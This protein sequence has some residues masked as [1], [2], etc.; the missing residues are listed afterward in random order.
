MVR[1][2]L[3]VAFLFH[4]VAFL[5]CVI[6]I[7]LTFYSFSMLLLLCLLCLLFINLDLTL[8]CVFTVNFFC[9][10]MQW[11]DFFVLFKLRFFALESGV[12]HILF[13]RSIPPPLKSFVGS[14]FPFTLNAFCAIYSLPIKQFLR[15]PFSL[16]QNYFLRGSCPIP[17]IFLVR[18]IPPSLIY[19]F[20]RSVFYAPKCILRGPFSLLPTHNFCAVCSPSSQLLCLCPLPAILLLGLFPLPSPLSPPYFFVWS[21]CVRARVVLALVLW[22]CCSRVVLVMCSRSCC[23]RVVLA[24]VLCLCC[25]HVVLALYLRSCCA[26]ARIVLVFVLVIMFAFAFVLELTYTL[27]LVFAVVLVSTLVVLLP[28]ALVF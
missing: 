16:P 19:F 26:R 23:T 8:L 12:L 24:F 1:I 14:P 10:F 22:S 13:A 17:P 7:V 4:F 15:G 21:R 11:I 5:R 28:L 20:V 27:I 25:A 6:L 18:F 2:F 3:V 9:V